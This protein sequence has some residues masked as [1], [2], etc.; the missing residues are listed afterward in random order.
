MAILGCLLSSQY[1]HAMEEAPIVRAL[2]QDV[3]TL[4]SD[5]LVKAAAVAHAIGGE[6]AQ[7]LLAAANHAFIDAM[8]HTVL[9]GL[10]SRSA[11]R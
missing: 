7:A 2:P 9:M 4:A 1:R 6:P 8:G 10:C 5:S 3:G 11:A